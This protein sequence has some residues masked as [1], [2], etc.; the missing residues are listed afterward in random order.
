M[1][2]YKFRSCST[3]S[4][5][6]ATIDQAEGRAAH[7]G[8]A[9]GVVDAP[10]SAGLAGIRVHQRHDFSRWGS[11]RHVGGDAGLPLDLGLLAGG[12]QEADLILALGLE[13]IDLED[14][15]PLAGKALQHAFDQSALRK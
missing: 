5:R 10:A 6:S 2:F 14:R 9:D 4:T 8:I 1:F 7:L 12:D 11:D 13:D 3:H 15:S